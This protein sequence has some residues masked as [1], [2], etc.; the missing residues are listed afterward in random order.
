MTEK[1]AASMHAWLICIHVCISKWGLRHS[2]DQSHVEAGGRDTGTDTG[3][4]EAEKWLRNEGGGA[5]CAPPVGQLQAH[6]VEGTTSMRILWHEDGCGG[7]LSVLNL[8]LNLIN[9]IYTN[10]VQFSYREFPTIFK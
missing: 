4:T 6:G 7:V 5:S 9:G 2:F 1:N 3:Q 8:S 10:I